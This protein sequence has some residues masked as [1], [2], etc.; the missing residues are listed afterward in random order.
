MALLGRPDRPLS[1]VLGHPSF[2]TLKISV[3]SVVK[4]FYLQ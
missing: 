1:P 3:G 4:F 2:S